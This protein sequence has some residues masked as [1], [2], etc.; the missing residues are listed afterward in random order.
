MHSIIYYTVSLPSYT[1]HN[2][3]RSVVQVVQNRNGAVHVGETLQV[4][5]V[6][7]GLT[8]LAKNKAVLYSSVIV[9]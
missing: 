2:I 6:R 8:S 5:F 1:F 4:K 7:A 9:L 3:E